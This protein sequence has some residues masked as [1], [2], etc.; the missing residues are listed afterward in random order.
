MAGTKMCPNGHVMD[1][2]WDRCP[3]CPDPAQMRAPIPPTRIGAAPP[4]APASAGSPG[5]AAGQPPADKRSHKK[6]QIVAEVKRTPVVGWLVALTGNHKGEDF[7]IREGRN[8]IG[9]D[10]GNEIVLTDGTVSSKHAHIN[11]IE[12]GDVR[13]FILVDMDSTNGTFLN[14]SSDPLSKEELVDGDTIAF[15]QVKTKFKCL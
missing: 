1:A 14:D 3:Y 10:P 9:S 12:K 5:A 7:R 11:Y 2:S 4:P 8:A 13:Q 15:G 6:T